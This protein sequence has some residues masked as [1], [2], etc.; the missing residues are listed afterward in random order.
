MRDEC[1]HEILPLP[2][3]TTLPNEGNTFGAMPVF[4]RVCP[5]NARTE[6]IFAPSVSWND[7]IHF[8]GTVRWYDY[9]SDDTTLTVVAS[10]ST[11]INYN[12]LFWWQSLPSEPGKWTDDITV[13]LQRSAFYRFFGIGP[14]TPT[15]AETSY[16]GLRAFVVTRRGLNVA[17]HVNVGITI[18]VEHDAVQAVGVPGLPLSPLVFPDTPGMKGATTTTQGIDLRYDDRHGGDYAERGIRLDAGGA[19]VEGLAGSPTFLRGA[20]QARGIFPEFGR[21]SGAARIAWTGVSSTAVPFYHQSSLGGSFLLR[22]FTEDRFINRQAWTV[23]LEERIRLFQTQIF[24]VVA[25]WRI[26]PFVDAGQVF[27][28]SATHSRGLASRGASGSAP[29]FTRTCSAG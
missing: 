13:R 22:G 5:E 4:L 14:D 29:S 8:T 2:V 17:P 9:P 24:G 3:Y 23:E 25:D 27:G 26:D 18:G 28:H 11:R 15:S 10:G 20:V 6:S 1:R 7:V 19:V 21:V 16:T 12:G